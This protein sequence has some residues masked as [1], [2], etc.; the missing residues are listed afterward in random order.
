MATTEIES[1][2]QRTGIDSAVFS[3]AGLVR[4][5]DLSLRSIQRLR[6]AGD[7]PA[8]VQLTG[9]LLR[10]RRADIDMWLAQRS[11]KAAA[12]AEEEAGR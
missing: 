11:A 5:L 3:S 2:A 12:R 8:P 9:T 4:Y 7:F 1:G 10:W 6:E